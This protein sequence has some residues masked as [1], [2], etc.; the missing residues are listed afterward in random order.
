LIHTQPGSSP[1]SSI[2][3][4]ISTRAIVRLL[5]GPICSDRNDASH[6]DEDMI[7]GWNA[8][9]GEGT[10]FQQAVDTINGRV[11]Y[12]ASDQ[13]DHDHARWITWLRTRAHPE[14]RHEAAGSDAR[15]GIPAGAR[16]NGSY[17]C[18][19]SYS[20]WITLYGGALAPIW[21]TSQHGYHPMIGA[22]IG[23]GN[24]SCAIVQ[25]PNREVI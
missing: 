8:Q 10:I 11:G 22:H 16:R 9:A 2:I 20:G 25:A 6:V 1:N 4:E 24:V 17:P 5:E 21:A 14:A 19:V 13:A 3:D 15:C 23:F 18:F 7:N 12:T